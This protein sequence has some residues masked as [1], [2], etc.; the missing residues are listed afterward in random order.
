L[1]SPSRSRGMPLF[2]LI[3]PQT[4]MFLSINVLANLNLIFENYLENLPRK[5]MCH[6]N[7]AR[8]KGT[9]LE[10]QYTFFIISRTFLLRKRNVS[11]KSCRENQNT[12]FVFRSF[13]LKSYRL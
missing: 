12:H 7:R 9:L 2:A 1:P 4:V 13:F 6:L 8:I 3:V 5:F 11:D 10:D